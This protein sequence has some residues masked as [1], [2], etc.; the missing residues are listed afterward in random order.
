[1]SLLSIIQTVA[2]LVGV[3][4]PS[5]VVTSTDQQVRQLFSLANEEGAELAGRGAWQQLTNEKLWVTIAAED[6]GAVVPADF[7]WCLPDTA[8]NRSTVRKLIGPVGA[9]EW[10][11]MKANGAVSTVDGVFRIR[12]SHLL[13]N[14]APTA[15]ETCAFE[16][17]SAYWAQTSAGVAKARFTADA[18]LTAL[19][20][21]LIEQG[22][23][24]RWNKAKGFEYGEDMR[25]YELNVQKALGRSGGE[26][27]LSISSADRIDP[28]VTNWAG[29]IDA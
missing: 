27:A 15:G 16:Y 4:R 28:L 22:I 20:E 12:G 18:D 19:P 26:R 14:P 6:Q 10:Q 5:V 7:G 21:S 23:R 17:V 2:D 3:T 24:W 1:M 9:Q 25:T 29:T 13:M 11:A 8:F